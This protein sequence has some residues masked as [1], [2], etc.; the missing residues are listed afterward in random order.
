MLSRDDNNLPDDRFFP[1]Q[2]ETSN[3][4]SEDGA[5]VNERAQIQSYSEPLGTFRL[6]LYPLVALSVVFL[7]LLAANTFTPFRSTSLQ[8]R[9]QI[10]G[11]VGTIWLL[12]CLA[13]VYLHYVRAQR[14]M[15][16]ANAIARQR[17]R[18]RDQLAALEESARNYAQTTDG[19]IV[20][21]KLRNERT[22]LSISKEEEGVSEFEPSVAEAYDALLERLEQKASKGKLR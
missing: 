4:K 3:V 18:L 12:G 10:A 7:F 1:K 19:Q 11:V 16:K 9:Y 17:E 8:I 2:I 14:F 20:L 15:H 13:F 22:L 6:I 5:S 21:E